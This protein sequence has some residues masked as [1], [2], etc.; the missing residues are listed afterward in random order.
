MI[1]VRWPFSGKSYI[2]YELFTV[3]S[4][5]L[6]GE[7]HLTLTKNGQNCSVNEQKHILKFRQEY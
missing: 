1:L 3:V 4:S 5:T 7:K 6:I 2:Y